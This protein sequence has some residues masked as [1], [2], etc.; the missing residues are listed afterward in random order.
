MST[1]VFI[2]V[3]VLGFVGYKYIYPWVCITIEKK[4]IEGLNQYMRRQVLHIE[5][6][7]ST[8]CYC[9][10]F[11]YEKI[12]EYDYKKMLRYCIRHNLKNPA[13]LLIN[14]TKKDISDSEH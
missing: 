9:W 14:R 10:D 4:R 7:K 3:I 2:L 8:I 6:D 1:F 11:D 5:E 13:E 12:S